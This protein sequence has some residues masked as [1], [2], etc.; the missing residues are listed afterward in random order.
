[1]CIR[2]SIPI[3]PRGRKRT[4]NEDRVSDL[5]FCDDR[6]VNVKGHLLRVFVVDNAVISECS[7]ACFGL[8]L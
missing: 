7:K 3:L 2:R 8:M 6:G 5:L 4:R 1:M